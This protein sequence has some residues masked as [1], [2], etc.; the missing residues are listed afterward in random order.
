MSKKSATSIVDCL[1]FPLILETINIAPEL[2]NAS[3]YDKG[4]KKH[5]AFLNKPATP[6]VCAI[7]VMEAPTNE[8][9]SE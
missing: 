3:K 7:H 5:K 9:S 1:W 8:S 4:K 6:T 2:K